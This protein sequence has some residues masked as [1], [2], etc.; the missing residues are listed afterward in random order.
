[1]TIWRVVGCDTNRI[2]IWD[3]EAV[4]FSSHSGSTHILNAAAGECLFAL[5]DEGPA[6]EATLRQRLSRRN[7]VE[8]DA[9]LADLVR[10]TLTE[11]DELGLIAEI[12]P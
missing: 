6:D 2:R 10:R 3:D 12:R 9:D 11:M 7:D 1:M 4:V 5:L 8:D